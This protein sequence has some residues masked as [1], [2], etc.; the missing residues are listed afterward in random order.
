MK[1][2]VHIL[3]KLVHLILLSSGAFFLLLILLSLTDYPYYA[4]HWTGNKTVSQKNNPAYIILMGAGGMPSYDAIIRCYYAAEAARK[5]P[6]SK[7]I[8]TLPVDSS[9]FLNSAHYRMIQE[10][11]LRGVDSTRI[12]SEYKGT[13]TYTQAVAIAKMISAVAPIQIVTSPVHQYRSIKTFEKQGFTN[14]SG[15]A[16]TE[17]AIDESLF[18]N[19]DESG[20]IEKDPASNLGLRYNLWSYLQYEIAV[21]REWL[22][23]VWYRIKGYM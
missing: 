8:V 6:E 1:R 17:S 5:N 7:I 10:L 12:L 9:D 4:Y 14:V 11:V 16:A 20:K 18:Y 3:S 13:N 23:I 19:K 21:M 15:L 2:I 22:A